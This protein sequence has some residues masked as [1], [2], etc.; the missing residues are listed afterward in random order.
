MFGLSTG[1]G[2]VAGRLVLSPH[3]DRA[4]AAAIERAA[5]S[6]ACLIAV[7][8]AAPW[9]WLLAA[10]PFASGVAI[11]VVVP[12]SLALGERY[13]RH[14]GTLFLLTCAQAGAMIMPALIGLA[15]RRVGLR[16][17]LSLLVACGVAIAAATRRAHAEPRGTI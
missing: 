10:A 5:F 3:V 6:G 1:L 9:T 7:F 14:A 15:A 12:T 2:L 4:T 16:L 11:A 17:A 13:P 8:A